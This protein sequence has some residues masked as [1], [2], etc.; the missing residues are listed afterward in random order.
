[1]PV[2]ELYPFRFRDPLTGKWIRARYVAEL[3]ETRQRCRRMGD[4]RRA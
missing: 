3:H 1:M 2:L 4:H